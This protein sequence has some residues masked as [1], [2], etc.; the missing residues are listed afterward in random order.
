[1]QLCSNNYP[2]ILA[3][4]LDKLWE[5]FLDESSDHQQQTKY[6]YPISR[7]FQYNIEAFKDNEIKFF[8]TIVRNNDSTN[9]LNS[10]TLLLNSI[11]ESYFEF[12]L[13]NDNNEEEMMRIFVLIKLGCENRNDSFLIV[14]VNNF[15]TVIS[16]LMMSNKLVF[17]SNRLFEQRIK[18]LKPCIEYKN[19][20]IPAF[21]S[22]SITLLINYYNSV[23]EGFFLNLYNYS[24]VL[25]HGFFPV[26]IRN[27][28]S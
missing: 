17:Y 26:K 19:E 27:S 2:Q 15:N 10:I 8:Q 20:L 24:G 1:V 12:F 18:G 16:R 5:Y 11:A 9:F 25:L 7:A 4:K 6:L 23:I 22:M 14:L 3:K 13:E 21:G 28:Y